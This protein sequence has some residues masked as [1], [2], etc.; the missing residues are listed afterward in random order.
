MPL[1]AVI[2]SMLVK[3]VSVR[4]IIIASGV[5]CG[6]IFVIVWAAKMPLEVTDEE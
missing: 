3:F 4:V 1:T 5:I 6:I 2:V